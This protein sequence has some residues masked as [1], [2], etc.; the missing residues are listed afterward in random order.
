MK[1]KGL[2]HLALTI[3]V[4]AILYFWLAP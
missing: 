3:L 1:K 2:V 4:V